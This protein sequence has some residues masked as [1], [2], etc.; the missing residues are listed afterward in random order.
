[1][2]ALRYSTI[3]LLCPLQLRKDDLDNGSEEFED[4]E[5]VG[6]G[7]EEAE[8]RGGW[9]VI[10]MLTA[11]RVQQQCA[12][13]MPAEGTALLPCTADSYSLVQLTLCRRCL[14]VVFGDLVAGAG[15]LHVI[16]DV[17]LRVD[18]CACLFDLPACLLSTAWQ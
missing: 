6:P 18:A 2:R 15:L 5:V 10:T 9:L 12:V 8:V 3:T 4:Y 13:A 11:G 1:M 7:D 16:D 14:Q 17:S